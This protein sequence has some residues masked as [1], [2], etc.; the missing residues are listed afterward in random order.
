MSIT[1]DHVFDVTIQKTDQWL[2]GIIRQ[3]GWADDRRRAY[4]A[5][6]AVL[7]ALRDRLPD[8]EVVDLGAQLPM[9]IR[10]VYYEGW[11]LNSDPHRL[12]KESDFFAKVAEAFPNDPS[13]DAEQITRAVFSVIAEHISAGE[14]KDIT[15]NLPDDLRTLWS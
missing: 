15:L 5:L 7:H 2:K 4:H 12:R 10:G 13:A 11:T 14:L 3:L 9:L 1:S 8:H 6:R